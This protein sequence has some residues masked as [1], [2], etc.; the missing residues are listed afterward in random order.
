[1]LPGRLRHEG[2]QVLIKPPIPENEAARLA[3][4]EH[5]RLNGMG[6]ETAFDRISQLAAR[7]FDMPMVLV[8][9]VG[10]D[11]QCFRGA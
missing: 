8:S 11:A 4:I 9:I 10:E 6:R 3:A 2:G 7:H 1:M 5:Y